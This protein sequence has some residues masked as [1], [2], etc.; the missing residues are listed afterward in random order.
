MLRIP[1][2][3]YQARFEFISGKK[4]DSSFYTPNFCD[5]DVLRVLEH[6]SAQKCLIELDFATPVRNKVF[7]SP[8]TF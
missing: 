8:Q 5:R 3:N 6:F 1:T 4:R 2:D 7:S